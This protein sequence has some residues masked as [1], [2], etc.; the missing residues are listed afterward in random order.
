MA[1]V[2][3]AKPSLAPL[4]EA[5]FS[6]FSWARTAVALARLFLRSARDVVSAPI[7]SVNWSSL[8]SRPAIF[9]FKVSTS[10]NRKLRSC[11]AL[12]SSVS[13]KVFFVA[14][15]VDSRKSRSTS[16]WI[17]S[18]TFAKGSAEARDANEVMAI[19]FKRWPSSSKSAIARSTL[20]VALAATPAAVPESSRR[21]RSPELPPRSCKNEGEVRPANICTRERPRSNARLFTARSWGATPAFKID[22]ASL[23]AL[24]SSAR[25]CE[26]WSQ[27][28]ARASQRS[29]KSLR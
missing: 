23:R 1:S 13:Q 24:S 25:N 17:N 29:V 27:S 3:A 26:R 6:A 12:P 15:A 19:L 20:K 9:T 2:S 18:F 7:S 22:N 10:V 14:S 21:D 4:T 5:I 11:V 8:T 16:R 28:F